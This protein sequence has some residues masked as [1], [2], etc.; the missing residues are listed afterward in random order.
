MV[1]NHFL[2]ANRS[3]L[4]KRDFTLLGWGTHL[5]SSSKNNNNDVLCRGSILAALDTFKR[6]W[7]SKKEYEEDSARAIERK[8][9]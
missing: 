3:Q 5:M 2:F 7:V 1:R 6:M 4:H 8:T 9:F